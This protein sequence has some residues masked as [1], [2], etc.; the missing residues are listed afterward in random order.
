[1]E[2]EDPTFYLEKLSI[3][4]DSEEDYNYEEV[5]K[6]TK[7]SSNLFDLSIDPSG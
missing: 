3:S 7:S 4:V 1:M 2:A 6:D 5:S